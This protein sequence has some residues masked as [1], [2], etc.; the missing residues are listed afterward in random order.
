MCYA[1]RSTYLP[2][3]GAL[4]PTVFG[5][6]SGVGALRMRSERDNFRM[7][8]IRPKRRRRITEAVSGGPFVDGRPVQRET[9]I[10]SRRFCQGYGTDRVTGT[11]TCWETPP[12]TV[13]ETVP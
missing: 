6:V 9:E 2:K 5:V 10:K 11:F 8:M 3:F 12:S 7:A 1:F 4:P 13:T